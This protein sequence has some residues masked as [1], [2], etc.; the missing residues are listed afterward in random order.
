MNPSTLF[1]RLLCTWASVAT[2]AALAALVPAAAQACDFKTMHFE[3]NLPRP[4]QVVISGAQPGQVVLYCTSMSAGCK[5]MREHLRKIGLDYLDKD[6]VNDPQA[7]AEFDALGG[8]GVPLAVFKQRLMHGY[9]PSS[10]DRLYA[11]YH[12]GT[13]VPPSP[14]PVAAAPVTP[15]PVLPAPAAPVAAVS[16]AA[17]AQPVI[18]KPA[19]PSARASASVH[20]DDIA[21]A[22]FAAYVRANHSVVVQFTSADPN[23]TFCV[24]GSFEE[25]NAVAASRTGPDIRFA[26]VQWSPWSKFPRELASFVNGIPFQAVFKGGR[27]VDSAQGSL[28][29]EKVKKE[30]IDLLDQQSGAPR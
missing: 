6:I 11:Q 5:G 15:A 18:A 10:F 9:Y 21:P 3:N 17:T 22:D 14:R 26:R 4:A 29:F 12:T 1:A 20:V 7:C 19:R 23:C 13:A 25:F 27:L 28:R 2:Y 30:L 24:D 16:A 8:Q